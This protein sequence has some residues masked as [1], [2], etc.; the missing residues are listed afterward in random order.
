MAVLSDL[1]DAQDERKA[2]MDVDMDQRWI[3]IYKITLNARDKLLLLKNHELNDKH[4]NASQKLLLHQFPSFQ[5]L[6]N[7]LVQDHIGFWTKNYIQIFH[8]PCHWITVSTIGCQSGTVNIYDSLFKDID[9]VTKHKIKEV[10]DS[11]IKFQLPK[12]QVQEG[13][14][15]CGLFGIAFAVALTFGANP[16][17]CKFDQSKMW[18][19]LHACFESTVSAN[20]LRVIKL[21]DTSTTGIL[22]CIYPL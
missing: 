18:P 2:V 17:A 13:L 21:Y 8:C 7:S 19:R 14:T 20:F 3:C 5:G 6:K 16:E 15:Q 10:F 4:I 12:V 9:G 1:E 11:A 22:L